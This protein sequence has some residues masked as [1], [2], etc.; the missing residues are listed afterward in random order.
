MKD[1]EKELFKGNNDKLISL[2]TI[3]K[4]TIFEE[5]NVKWNM[6][7][8]GARNSISIQITFI[9]IFFPICFLLSIKFSKLLTSSI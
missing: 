4:Y 1:F 2:M 3:S 7:L 9:Y 5:N 8:N 6:E